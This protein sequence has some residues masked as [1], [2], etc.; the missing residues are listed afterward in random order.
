MPLEL[1]D[2]ENPE[3][4]IQDVVKVRKLNNDE[5]KRFESAIVNEKRCND[6]GVRFC[7]YDVI[8]EGQWIMAVGE[9]AHLRG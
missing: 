2:L 3:K 8:K 1:N 6:K 9:Y 4:D 5:I 7:S